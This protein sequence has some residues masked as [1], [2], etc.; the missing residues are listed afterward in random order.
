MPFLNQL[1]IAGSP[2][3]I[4]H[5]LGRFGAAT[6]HEYAQQSPAWATVMEHRDRP[7]V[8]Q[9]SA[10]VHAQ[11]P[12]VWD[13]L[14][15]LATGL[16]LPFEEVFLWNCRGDLWAMAP[17]G[18]TTVQTTGDWP[19]ITHNEDG[20]PAF[21]GACALAIC[22]VEGSASFASFV[23]PG[24]LPGHTFAVTQNGLAMTVN[25]LRCL[26]VRPGIPRM[27]L[28]RA[29][30]DT[31][32]LDEATSLLRSS[33][34]AGGFHLTLAHRG[35]SELL[36]VEFNSQSCSVVT[37]TGQKLHAN[38]ATHDRLQGLPQIVTGSSLH[39]QQ[40]GDALLAQS[41]PSQA[42]PLIVLADQ[43]NA[44]FPILRA[45]P[46]DQDCEN[47]H[48]TAD[49]H[50]KSSRIDWQVCV[51]SSREP[52]FHMID[53]HASTEKGERDATAVA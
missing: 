53:A 33:E 2:F 36:S 32:C 8:K 40:R 13:E 29:L 22:E 50:V 1:D 5:A 16:E 9:M 23:Y 42:D 11:F 19:R 15:G 12:R 41:Q 52:I 6:M 31:S 4:G 48:A 24:S 21:A 18:C 34:R 26:D 30:L 17:D 10:R 49:I 20:D 25:N 37:I 43:D 46:D 51:R 45:D 47:T 7:L 3:D 28:T 35:A 44:I 14:S 39:R 27:V 38:H